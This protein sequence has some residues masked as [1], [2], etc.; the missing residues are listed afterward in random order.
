MHNNSK[1]K[2]INDAR[3]NQ[4]GSGERGDK[5]RTY[6]VQDGMVKDDVSGKRA[7]IRD[8]YRGYIGQLHK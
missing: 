5:R 4:I 7:S 2:E 3:S 6:R 8:I 1:H